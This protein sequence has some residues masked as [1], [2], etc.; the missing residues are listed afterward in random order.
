MFDLA[1]DIGETTNV[2]GDHAE[3]VTRLQ[4]LANQARAELGDSATKQN[5]AGV[6]PPGRLPA[7]PKKK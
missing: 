1:Q 6:R 7:R 3:V 5:G 4:A 2:I